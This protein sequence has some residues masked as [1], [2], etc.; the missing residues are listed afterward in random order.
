MAEFAENLLAVKFGIL[1]ACPDPFLP[2]HFRMFERVSSSVASFGFAASVTIFFIALVG[3]DTSTS[4]AE[5]ETGSTSAGTVEL[6]IDF[7]SDQENISVRIPC[8]TDSTVWSILDRARNLGDVKFESRGE[9]ETAF[10]TSIG[11]VENQAAAGDNWV[12]RV[13]GELG[14]KSCGVFSVKPGDQVLWVFGKYP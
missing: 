9:G 3:C 5:P 10:V 8:S 13:N 2:R 4:V 14:D 12:Y 1:P 11:G 7:Q 6:E